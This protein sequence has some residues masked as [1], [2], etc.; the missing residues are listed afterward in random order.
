ALWASKK[1]LKVDDSIFIQSLEYGISHMEEIISSESRLS[2]VL[3]REY[4]TKEL[5]YKI[6]EKDRK[7]FVLFAEKCERLNLL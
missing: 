6:T 7:G 5:H 1:S 2:P 4:L 3:V